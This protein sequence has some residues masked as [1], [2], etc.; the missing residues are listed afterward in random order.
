MLASP[1]RQRFLSLSVVAGD[2]SD[3]G[4]DG[5]GGDDDTVVTVTNALKYPLDDMVTI[6]RQTLT[7]IVQSYG[8]WL[9][10]SRVDA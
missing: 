7:L 3:G 8:I 9:S 5:D 2:G 4:V 10:R 1:R 6:P